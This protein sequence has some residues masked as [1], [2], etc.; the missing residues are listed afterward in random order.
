MTTWNRDGAGALVFWIVSVTSG[1]CARTAGLWR[2]CGS[3][4]VAWM[5]IWAVGCGGTGSTGAPGPDASRDVLRGDQESVTVD[6]GPSDAARDATTDSATS[7]ATSDDA[8]SNTITAACAASAKGYCSKY[9]SCNELELEYFYGSLETCEQRVEQFCPNQYSAPGT[10]APPS[11]SEAEACAQATSDQ[12]CAQ[13][14]TGVLPPACLGHAGSESTGAPCEY[15]GQCQ[16]DFC[17]VASGSFCGTCQLAPSI[18]Q[19]CDSMYG[20]ANGLVCAYTSCPID[21]GP[22][23]DEERSICFKPRGEGGECDNLPDCEAPLICVGR[24]CTSLIPEGSPCDG[25][26]CA[27][28]EGLVCATNPDGGAQTCVQE[29]FAPAGAECNTTASP[30]TFCAASGSCRSTTGEAAVVGTCVAAAADGQSCKNALCMPPAIC[31]SG[32]CQAP[33]P[34]SSCK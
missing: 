30:P 21:G 18:G 29:K 4:V 15:N 25:G 31:V 33:V 16:S 5:A 7:D 8:G 32:T 10:T 2:R 13:F 19:A 11:E 1:V 14:L 17:S 28:T 12:T 27:I 24:A 20:C 26:G 3:A 34:A 22:C 23:T 9:L 6:S